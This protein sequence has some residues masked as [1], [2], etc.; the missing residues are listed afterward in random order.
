[1][2]E[3]VVAHFPDLASAQAAQRVLARHGFRHH[4]IVTLLP[5]DEGE[6]ASS[7][8]RF[9]HGPLVGAAVGGFLGLL[10][11]LTLMLSPGAAPLVTDPSILAAG[12]LVADSVA[13]IVYGLIG[14]CVGGIFGMIVA[15][16]MPESTLLASAEREGAASALLVLHHQGSHLDKACRILESHGADVFVP[17]DRQ[18]TATHPVRRA[19]ASPLS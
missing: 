15:L 6:A 13:V 18:S 3:T 12:P 1:M 8:D 4:E 7:S 17:P 14:M 9:W 5:V 2:T 10:V 16:G 19:S 11:S